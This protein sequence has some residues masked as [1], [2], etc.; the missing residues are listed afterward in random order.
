MHSL[1]WCPAVESPVTSA[2]RVQVTLM[3][4]KKFK[5]APLREAEAVVQMTSTWGAG[6]APPTA[7]AWLSYL[8]TAEAREARFRP[9]DC[10]CYA[11][12]DDT[13]HVKSAVWRHRHTTDVVCAPE[14]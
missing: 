10:H 6:A 13:E 4:C 8:N 7:R 3:D 5:T 14:R 2:A 11:V 12:S 1:Q 9:I